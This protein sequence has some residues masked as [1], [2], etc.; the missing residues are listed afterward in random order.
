[1][2]AS[3]DAQMTRQNA[4]ASIVFIGSA[5]YAQFLE[6]LS[7]MITSIEQRNPVLAMSILRPVISSKYVVKADGA[8]LDPFPTHHQMSKPK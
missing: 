3:F 4:G 6:V 7:A 8:L 2:Y 5:A 1:M